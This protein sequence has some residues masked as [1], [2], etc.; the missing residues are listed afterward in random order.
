[1][2]G[3][4]ENRFIFK[5]ERGDGTKEGRLSPSREGS[6]AKGV[7][8]WDTQG[9]KCHTQTAFLNPD[10]FKQWYGI[11]N[12]ARVKVNGERCMALLDN[13]MQINTI[14]PGYV[15]NHSLDVRPHMQ[16]GHLH[17]PGKCPHLT[18]WLHHIW[19]QVNGVQGSNED[20]IALVIPDL[21][22]FAAQ[23]PV[24]LRIPMIGH[25][26]N[27]IKESEIDALTTPW[28]NVQVAYLFGSK[29]SHCHQRR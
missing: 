11:E 19:I 25:V 26:M 7:P 29:M 20:Q 3:G 14:T 24:I 22:N 21:S 15:E 8:G 2:A 16:S 10:P 5:L 27:V 13:G 1:M 12:V 6:H 23:V 4:N 9:I 17:R 18:N 28:V